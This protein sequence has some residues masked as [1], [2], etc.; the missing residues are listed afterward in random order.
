[1]TV[2]F[3]LLPRDFAAWLLASVDRPPR[4]R[5]RDQAPD[6][7]GLE[8]KRRV[9]DRLIILDPKPDQM[10]AALAQIVDE[11][12]APTGPTRAVAVGIHEEWHAACQ[13]EGLRDHLLAEATATPAEQRRGR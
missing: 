3:S 9:L 11:F 1:M 2:A 10:E 7:A 6:R 5:A 12:G 8:L 13:S 4:Q